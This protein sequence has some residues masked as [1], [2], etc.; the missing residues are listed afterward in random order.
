MLTCI[1]FCHSV[2]GF[3]AGST[4]AGASVYYYILKEFRLSNETLKGDIYVRYCI[5]KKARHTILWAVHDLGC[6][7]VLGLA[8]YLPVSVS[9]WPGSIFGW[10]LRESRM[11]AGLVS[12]EGFPAPL[13]WKPAGCCPLIRTLE[14]FFLFLFP[15]RFCNSKI[16]LPAILRFPFFPP[17]SPDDLRRVTIDSRYMSWYERWLRLWIS[18]L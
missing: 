12:G 18:L 9:L 6:L 15:S 10:P 14:A 4:L 2:F 7:S 13:S 5:W 17:L 1:S 8:V 11:Q 3:L 16:C